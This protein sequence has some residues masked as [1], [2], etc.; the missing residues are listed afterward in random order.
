[1]QDR[2]QNM[3]QQGLR[4]LGY[5]EGDNLVIEARSNDRADLLPISG[6]VN[7]RIYAF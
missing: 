4:E 2:R 3:L 1:M 7:G 5:V 6:R